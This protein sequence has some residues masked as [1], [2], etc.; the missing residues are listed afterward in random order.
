MGKWV[1]RGEPINSGNGEICIFALSTDKEIHHG[2]TAW[3]L[4]GFQVAGC[5]E[6]VA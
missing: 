4:V 1:S 5:A 6:S 2:K 3:Y